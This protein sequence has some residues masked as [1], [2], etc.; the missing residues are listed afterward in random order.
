M[1]MKLSGCSKAAKRAGCTHKEKTTLTA[2]FAGNQ[3][4]QAQSIKGN[5]QLPRQSP[6]RASTTKKGKM[7]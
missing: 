6:R 2:T 5:Y 4:R 7:S 1:N 3:G